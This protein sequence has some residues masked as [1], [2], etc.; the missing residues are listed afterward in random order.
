MRDFPPDV[1]ASV[2]PDTRSPSRF[3]GWML[4]VQFD[5]FVGMTLLIVAWQLPNVLSPWLLGRAID[6]GIIGRDPLATVG[7]A[8]LLLAAI[9]FGVVGL[10]LSGGFVQDIFV[11]LGEAPGVRAIVLMAGQLGGTQ[12]LEFL[13]S[14]I[15]QGDGQ[16][17]QQNTPSLAPAGGRGNRGDG[18]ISHDSFLKMSSG[19]G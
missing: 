14:D 9:V 16:D 19:V 2:I 6:S 10:I 15:E 3:L 5:V 12:Q 7:W 13:Q 4:R 8:A 11:Q 1:S 18:R 17:G